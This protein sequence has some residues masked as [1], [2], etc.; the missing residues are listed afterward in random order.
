[1]DGVEQGRHGEH[2]EKVG[3]RT[4]PG[5]GQLIDTGGHAGDEAKDTDR[6]QRRS[7]D[8]R[9]TLNGHVF[10]RRHVSSFDAELLTCVW[11]KYPGAA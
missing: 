7:H 2:A 11:K 6:R 3:A 4:L 10:R 8:H 1:V 9:C 5:P